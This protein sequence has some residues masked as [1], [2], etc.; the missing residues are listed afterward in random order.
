LVTWWIRGPMV[1]LIHPIARI[2]HVI[3]APDTTPAR[4][5]HHESSGPGRNVRHSKGIN[6]AFGGDSRQDAGVAALALAAAF[7]ACL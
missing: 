3:S 2:N 5:T 6:P 4:S 7:R 1:H